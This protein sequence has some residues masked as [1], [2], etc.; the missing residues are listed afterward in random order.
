MK[1]VQLFS[2]GLANNLFQQ[3]DVSGKSG[4]P[5]LR[6]RASGERFAILVG[7]C[8]RDVARFL[9]RLQMHAQVSVRHRK[10]I[11]H[12]RERQFGAGGQ[13]RHDGHAA[14]FMDDAVELKGGESR[15]LHA[16]SLSFS[17]I[18]RYAPYAR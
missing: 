3:V 10:R 14:F 1:F 17:V 5:G 6:Q 11:T 15:C 8:D 4:A 7:F 16:R 9:Q 12:F 2:P 13:Q 18:A